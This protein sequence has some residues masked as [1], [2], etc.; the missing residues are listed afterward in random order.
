MRG[1]VLHPSINKSVVVFLLQDHRVPIDR[2]QPKRTKQIWHLSN[3]ALLTLDN[4]KSFPEYSNISKL[5]HILLNKFP[6]ILITCSNHK[7]GKDLILLLGE[8]NVLKYLTIV[9]HNF[10]TVFDSVVG[11][12]RRNHLPLAEIVSQ[13]RVYI[14]EDIGIPNC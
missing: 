4:A 9:K 14:I 13:K 7:G 10:L 11:L 2:L 5:K 12:T 1:N 3:G 8:T 6:I